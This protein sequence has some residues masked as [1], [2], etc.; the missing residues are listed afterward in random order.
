MTWLRLGGVLAH[1]Q[2]D[3]VRRDGRSE[4]RTWTSA[5]LGRTCWG[6]RCRRGRGEH[7]ARRLVFRPIPEGDAPTCGPGTDHPTVED[8]RRYED[9]VHGG[10]RFRPP[11]TSSMSMGRKSDSPKTADPHRAPGPQSSETL[12]PADR[13]AAAAGGG[14]ERAGRPARRRRLRRLERVRGPC[15][16]PTAERLAAGA[17]GTTASTPPPCARR[18]GRRCSPAATTTRSGWAA[19]PRRRRR[20]RATAR[21][22][23]T[24]RRRWR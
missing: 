21:C 3:P 4:P 2:Q 17:C 14:A 8:H 9:I 16:T 10:G 13:A 1:R 24:P 18:R 20:R 19:S 12:E 6:C 15:Q 22:A 11:S 23:R 5:R 7:P